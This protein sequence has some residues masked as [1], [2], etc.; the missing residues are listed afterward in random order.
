MAANNHRGNSVT[1]AREHRHKMMNDSVASSSGVYRGVAAGVAAIS[2]ISIWRQAC[3]GG[4]DR[5]E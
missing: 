3:G 4:R 2:S 5:R 1:A